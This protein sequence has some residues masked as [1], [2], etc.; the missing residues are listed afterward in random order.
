[1]ARP[2]TVVDIQHAR[3]R[4]F[5]AIP[6]RL[7]FHY[8]PRLVIPLKTVLRV[9][10]LLFTFSY[11]LFGAVAVPI[12]GT[13]SFAASD[14]SKEEEKAKLTQE[15]NNLEKEIADHEA[16]IAKL[17][18]QGKS[19]QSEVT[20]LQ[21]QINTVN[22]KIKAVTLSLAR[23][24]QEM[25][26]N[27]NQIKVTEDKLSL[28]KEGL[29]RSLQKAYEQDST[30]LMEVLLMNPTLSDFFRDVNDLHNLQDSLS[31]TISKVTSLKNDLLDQKENLALQRNDAAELKAY[32]DRQRASIAAIKKEKADLLTVTKG[33]ESQYKEILAE[34]RKTAAQIRSQIFKL[35][36]GGELSFPDA[37]GLAKVAEKATGVRAALLLA[38]LDRESALGQNVGRCGYETAMHP[39]RDI[40]IFL[41]I[42]D[43]LGLRNDLN[44]GLI[45][46]SCPIRSDGAFGGAIGPAQFLPSTWNLY[47]SAIANVTGNNPP[48][49][50]NNGDAF[51]G[52]ALYLRDVYN[53]QGCKDYAAQIP[54]QRQMLQERCAAAK[55][56]A[57]SRW[58]TYRFA[59]GDPVV[60]Q[61]DQFQKDIDVLNS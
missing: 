17:K 47:E 35:I 55:Y 54:S 16:T 9:S 8:V 20:T 37:Y 61:A 49:P 57:G 26:D 18:A 1:M 24:N 23:I 28:N 58:Y 56:Y 25:Q 42:I 19:L 59:Y 6:E 44:S 36:G 33:Q 48:S 13:Q 40:P 12:V 41:Q 4:A 32:Q 51:V 7:N 11:L 30:G 46:V 50:W 29:K 34:R 14:Q 27:Q 15:L 31:I 2:K 53:S 22:L 21:A 43:R 45:K 5:S 10:V 52:T 60:Q 39:T 38:V 3:V